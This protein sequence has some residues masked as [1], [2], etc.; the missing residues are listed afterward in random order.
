MIIFRLIYRK[1]I[2]NLIRI[3]LLLIYKL[4]VFKIITVG[5]IMGYNFYKLILLDNKIGYFK[6]SFLFINLIY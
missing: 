4:I 6:M 1:L 3:N 2:F 5:I